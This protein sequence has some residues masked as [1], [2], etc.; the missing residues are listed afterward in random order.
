M[1]GIPVVS[2]NTDGIVV[3]CPTDKYDLM[4]EVFAAWEQRTGLE[5]EETEY[6]ALYSRD[7]NNYIAVKMDG[8]TKTKGAYCERGSAHNSVLSKNPE[9]LICSDAAQAYLSKGTPVEQT[10]R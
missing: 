1:A 6:R 7:V 4:L 10:I 3:A 5:T 8:K 9:V 2:A